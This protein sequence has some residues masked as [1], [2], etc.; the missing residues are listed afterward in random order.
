MTYLFKDL[1]KEIIIRR[2]EKVGYLGVEVGL[3]DYIGF[4]V[5]LLGG[6]GALESR[7]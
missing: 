3:R 7:Y 6:S 4:M 1:Y 5:F 2:R